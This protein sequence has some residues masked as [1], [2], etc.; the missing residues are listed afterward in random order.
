MTVLDGNS[1]TW[2]STGRELDGEI[3]PNIEPVK[4]V[5]GDATL[6][7]SKSKEGSLP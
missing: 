5:R 2:Q 7:D 4:V 1:F 6:A 3:L